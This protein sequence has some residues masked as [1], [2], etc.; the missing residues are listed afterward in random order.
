MKKIICA[1]YVLS[2]SMAIAGA[3]YVTVESE[4]PARPD[5]SG[6]TTIF[7]GTLDMPSSLWK[8]F[9]YQ[10]QDEWLL[11]IKDINDMKFKIHMS[12]RAPGKKIV[13]PV[14][15]FT[16]EAGVYVKL[17]YKGF[18]QKTGRAY[19]HDVDTLDVIV[20]MFDNKTRKQLY[21]ANL[22][23]QSTGT[24]KRGWMMNTLEGRIDNQIY[25]L[26]DFIAGKF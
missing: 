26:C 18:R 6:Y 15:D 17:A 20:T 24:F 7:M 22:G 10:N 16:G 2:F 11:V 3:K 23:A 4:S 8:T 14:G 12:D 13:A 5:L 25:N 19:A 21:T 1:I 9:G